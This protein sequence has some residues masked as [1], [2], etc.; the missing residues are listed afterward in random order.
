MSEYTNKDTNL[1]N[2]GSTFLRNVRKHFPHH[3]IRIS[4]DGELHEFKDTPDGASVEEKVK[5]APQCIVS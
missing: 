3:T 5:L 4:E 1:D 2:R